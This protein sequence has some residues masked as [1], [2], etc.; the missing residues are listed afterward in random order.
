MA[1]TDRY[2]NRQEYREARGQAIEAFCNEFASCEDQDMLEDILVTVSRLADDGADRGDLKLLTNSLKELRYAFKVFAPYQ[3]VRKVSMFGSSRTPVDHPDYKQAD[4][5]ARR[6]RKKKWM[7]ITGAG[8][9]IMRA[10]HLG[11]GAAASFGVAIRL[12]FEQDAN[13]IIADDPKLVNFRYFFTRKLLFMKEASAVALFPG[14][15]GTQDEGFEALTL[16]QTGKTEMIPVVMVDSPG[17]NY[18][19][20]WLKF[21]ESELLDTNMIS[22]ED[23]DL[24]KITND[25]EEAVRYVTDFYRRYHSGRYV[26][27][28]LVLRMES[29]LS[30]A[31]LEELNERYQHIITDGCIEQQHGPLTGEFNELPDKVRLVFSFDRKSMGWLRRMVDDIN[32]AP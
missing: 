7:V 17:G 12:P 22:P 5:F 29:A 11:A 20:R 16:I 25:V 2:R 3:H 8:D 9:G 4:E 30:D 19:Q 23:M 18:W 1:E 24:F 13:A 10:G 31:S 15:F 27:E 6:L 21:V 26:G 14:G 32:R 28:K